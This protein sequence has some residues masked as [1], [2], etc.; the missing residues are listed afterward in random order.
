MTVF[1]SFDL[2]FPALKEDFALSFGPK[3]PK[4]SDMKFKNI[5]LNMFVISAIQAVLVS[6]DS[7]ANS[8]VPPSKIDAI[9]FIP[10]K[11]IGTQL[12]ESVSRQKFSLSENL[13]G[14]Q[15][16]TADG[17]INVASERIELVA[18]VE[19]DGLN[20]EGEQAFSLG[21]HLNGASILAQNLNLNVTV[22]KDLG[23]GWA[24]LNLNMQCQQ[25]R[26]SLTNTNPI[27]TDIALQHGV[28]AVSRINWNLSSTAVQTELIGCNEVAGFDEELR[29]Q[30]KTF[31]QQSFA[32]DNLKN[33]INS[34]LNVAINTKITETLAKI[35]ATYNLKPEQKHVI[36]EKNNLWIYTNDT[37]AASFAA[38]D[39]ANLSLSKKASM[40]IKKSSVEN[41]I[42]TNL[43]EFLKKNLIT[44]KLNSGLSRLTCSRWV[45]FF[46]WPALF[47]MNRCFDLQIQNQIES[48]QLQNLNTLQMNVKLSSWAAGDGRQLAY[49]NSQVL[50]S[51]L[52]PQA[53]LMAF[54]GQQ[55]P[56]YTQWSR[57]STRISTGLFKSALQTLLNSTISDLAKKDLFAMLKK[58]SSIKQIGQDAILIEMN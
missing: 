3:W 17:S 28:A 37:V 1:E 34:K 52:T 26:I 7:I 46:V 50:V 45:Q 25:L 53:Q 9:V 30:I 29:S 35:S 4:S 57:R 20:Q 5:F 44:S 55:D 24:T 42:K 15:T 56:A 33:L 31:I 43:N 18:Q 51:P 48:V 40:L 11:Q 54:N 22:K 32:L 10:F 41:L 8:Q 13:P 21:L 58:K 49:F 47:G 12:Q 6:P 36:D 16:Q 19:T 38:A 2:E 27:S 39:L 23:F 14:F